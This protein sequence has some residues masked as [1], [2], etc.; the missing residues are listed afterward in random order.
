MLDVFF[1][2]FISFF[3]S[4]LHN[5]TSLSISSFFSCLWFEDAFLPSFRFFSLRSSFLFF[6]LIPLLKIIKTNFVT[7]FQGKSKCFRTKNNYSRHFL[8]L[9]RYLSPSKLPPLHFNQKKIAQNSINSS[10]HAI[11][12][13]RWQDETGSKPR[14]L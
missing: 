10:R 5:H 12:V 8:R 7:F 2:S 13:W 6:F 4:I 3:L 14:Y 11:F 9:S 1:F